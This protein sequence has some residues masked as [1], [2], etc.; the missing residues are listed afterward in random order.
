MVLATRVLIL[1]WLS[2][3]AAK[4]RGI[5]RSA[6]D[7]ARNLREA[8]RER[9]RIMVLRRTWVPTGDRSKESTR[10]QGEPPRVE[11]TLTKG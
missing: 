9:R 5:S 1:A 7:I 6:D 11:K 2:D 8:K 3:H 4:R 10:S